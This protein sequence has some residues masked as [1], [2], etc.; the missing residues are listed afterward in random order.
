MPRP[1]LIA[2][3]G[4]LLAIAL[5]ACVGTAGGQS[6]E[7]PRA[8]VTPAGPGQCDASRADYAIGRPWTEALGNELLAATGARQF[9][10]I[11]YNGAATMDFQEDR[12]TISLDAERKVERISCG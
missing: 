8:V 1:T 4:A 11:P 12:L 2:T 6:G 3:A 9:R 10:A 5:P 7:Q